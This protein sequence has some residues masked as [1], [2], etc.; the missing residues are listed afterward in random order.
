ML[1]AV[2]FGGN[3]NNESNSGSRCSN[4]NNAPSN[5]NNNIG[6]RAVCGDSHFTSIT[7]RFIE[8]VTFNCGQI[9]QPASANTQTGSVG[10]LVRFSEYCL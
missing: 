6:S 3:W 7:L 5:S 9:I 2:L 4:W 10:Q 8:W 1:Y